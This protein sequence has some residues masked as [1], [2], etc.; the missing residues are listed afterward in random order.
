M[1]HPQK[2]PPTPP[3]PS[4]EFLEPPDTTGQARRMASRVTLVA[5]TQ[6]TSSH[7]IQVHMSYKVYT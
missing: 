1:L 3:G 4:H 6:C 7:A 2:Q 5:S